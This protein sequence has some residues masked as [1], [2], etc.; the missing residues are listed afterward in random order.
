MIEKKL[1]KEAKKPKIKE[2]TAVYILFLDQ[3]LANQMV[4]S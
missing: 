4:I 2:F 1:L 3:E